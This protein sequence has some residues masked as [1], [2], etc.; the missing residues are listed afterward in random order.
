M[1][2]GN[3]T[4]EAMR[5]AGLR[6]EDFVEAIRLI[7]RCRVELVMVPGMSIEAR[8]E[9]AANEAINGQIGKLVTAV[10]IMQEVLD[11]C[12][13][14]RITIETT[15]TKPGVSRSI[16]VHTP[17]KVADWAREL[18]ALLVNGTPQVETVR[19]LFPRVIERKP[20][21]V[22]AHH[23]QTHLVLGG[24]AKSTVARSKSKQAE[25][26]WFIKL[27]AL[28]QERVS[29]VSFK[30]L[31]H[32]LAKDVPGMLPPRHHLQN[33]G[34]DELRDVSLRVVQDGIRPPTREL[35]RLIRAKTGRAPSPATPV[36]APARVMKADRTGIEFPVL[37]YE[38]PD[39]QAEYAHHLN[40]SVSQGLARSRSVMRTALNPVRNILLGN[41]APPGCGGGGRA[42]WPVLRPAEIRYRMEHPPDG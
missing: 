22:A 1:Q 35:A 39:M 10:T 16:V 19:Q 20:P 18:P 11:G 3:L 2:D 28:G 25:L 38:D 5:A 37:R 36:M 8:R 41:V 7:R 34:D 13:P 30:S 23:A 12:G 40:G 17:L 33:A 42:D 26:N 4:P 24:F 21:E 15:T 14:G 27:Q 31:K 6:Q 9:A 32:V 29:L